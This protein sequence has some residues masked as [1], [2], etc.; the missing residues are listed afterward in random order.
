[1]LVNA[2]LISGLGYCN[3]LLYG[4]LNIKGTGFK[5]FDCTAARVVMGLKRS[6][7]GGFRR[8]DL[9]RVLY[10]TQRRAKLCR[11]NAPTTSL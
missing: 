6:D 2:L 10:A 9:S 3:S 8:Y 11:M 1:M 7:K 4:T 5:E